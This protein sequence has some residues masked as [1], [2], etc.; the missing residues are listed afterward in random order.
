MSWINDRRHGCVV[1]VHW[2]VVNAGVGVVNR[3]VVNVGVRVVYWHVV[4]AAGV[5]YRNVAF[6]Q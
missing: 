1:V 4:N 5:F 6:L 3:H 2:Q